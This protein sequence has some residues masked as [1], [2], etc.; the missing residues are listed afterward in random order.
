M[1]RPDH[2]PG[3]GK[4]PG[5]TAED[6]I[7]RH[8]AA[9]SRE[10]LR[11]LQHLVST[12]ERLPS[13]PQLRSSVLA[14]K[15]RSYQDFCRLSDTRTVADE[16]RRHPR[17]DPIMRRS[18]EAI[19]T[20][21]DKFAVDAVQMLARSA[22]NTEHDLEPSLRTM[23]ALVDRAATLVEDGDTLAAEAASRRANRLYTK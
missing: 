9:L 11:H 17:L 14:W 1:S 2:G 4:I 18:F 8:D 10:Y 21:F 7:G 19:V 15:P 3:D 12:I 22:G 23:R 5:R 6:G 20:A 16:R 13:E